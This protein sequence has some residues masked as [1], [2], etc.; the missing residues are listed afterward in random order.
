[1]STFTTYL[2]NIIIIDDEEYPLMKIH[3]IGNRVIAKE[4]IREMR[5]NNPEKLIFRRN[6]GTIGVY[7]KHSHIFESVN[8]FKITIL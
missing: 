3:T 1:M 7:K 6:I 5:K 8:N 2:P 4:R